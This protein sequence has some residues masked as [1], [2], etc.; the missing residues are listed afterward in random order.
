MKRI[1]SI[2]ELKPGDMIWSID[3][4]TVSPTILEYL[5]PLPHNDNYSIFI[6]EFKEPV[7]YY[8]EKFDSNKPHNPEKWFVYDGSE[9]CWDEIKAAQIERYKELIEHCNYN[10]ARRRNKAE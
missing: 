7:R 4:A 8:N 9:Q 3:R 2:S 6:N 5:C 10:P 1:N